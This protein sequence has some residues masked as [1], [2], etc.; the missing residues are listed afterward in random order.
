MM[1]EIEFP[2]FVRGEEMD[3]HRL[4]RPRNVSVDLNYGV[5][6]LQLFVYGEPY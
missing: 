3:F 6:C 1:K 5:L 4:A 2:V